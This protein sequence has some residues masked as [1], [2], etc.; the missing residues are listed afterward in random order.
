MGPRGD[1][2]GKR[3]GSARARLAAG[4]ADIALVDQAFIAADPDGW[5]EACA[6]R[7]G[8]TMLVLMSEA[9]GTEGVAPPFELAALRGAL[10][11]I[12][13]ECV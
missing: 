4:G 11:G 9:A 10:R 12:S 3:R 2:G 8:R 5:R 7:T 13:K 6:A 1:G